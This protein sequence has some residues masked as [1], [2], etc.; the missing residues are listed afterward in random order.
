[1]IIPKVERK[2]IIVGNKI[3]NSKSPRICMNAKNNCNDYKVQAEKF[4]SR[5]Q[6]KGMLLSKHLKIGNGSIYTQREVSPNLSQ[7]KF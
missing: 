1:M 5:A 6:H 7:G 4:S 2:E 3:D